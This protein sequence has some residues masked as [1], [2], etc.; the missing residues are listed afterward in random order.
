[1]AELI[2]LTTPAVAPVLT[3]YRVVSLAL[4]WEEERIV[5]KLLA[6]DGQRIGH[7][8]VGVTALTLMRALNKVDLSV[9]SLQ[10]RILERLV[11][12]GVIA[13]VISGVPD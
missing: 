6:P 3:D 13:G 7:N 11:A 9:K 8:Y 5:I 10:R 12:D 4:D 1:M 2:T